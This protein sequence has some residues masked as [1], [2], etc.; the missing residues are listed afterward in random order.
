MSAICLSLPHS[1]HEGTSTQN[2]VLCHDL[3]YSLHSLVIYGCR[4][5]KPDAY[6]HTRMECVALTLITYS[7]ICLSLYQLL[8]ESVYHMKCA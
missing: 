1:P 8:Y 7:V 6:S 5:Y 2:S 3:C 4:T